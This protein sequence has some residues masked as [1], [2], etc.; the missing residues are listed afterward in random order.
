MDLIVYQM[1]QFQIMHVSDGYGAVKVL[2]RSAVT[3]TDL[4]VAG[5][6]YALPQ[7]SVLSVVR[8]IL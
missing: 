4:T 1:M 7:L 5:D 6:R 8:Q 3:Q 2:T